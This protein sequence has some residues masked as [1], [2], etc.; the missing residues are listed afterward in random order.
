VTAYKQFS[1]GRGLISSG[2]DSNGREG[3][4]S[5]EV[6][7]ELVEAGRNASEVLELVEEAFNEVSL[8]VD[9]RID[10][11]LNPPV[12]LGWDVSPDAVDLGQID[13]SP[14][15]ITTI[16]DQV[17]GLGE[18]CDQTDR[19]LFIGGLAWCQR[20]ADGQAITID[21]SIDLST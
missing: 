3:D 10:G 7:G 11:S 2:P 16:G 4:G 8:P 9:F 13:K 21:D 14:S 6:A 1:L 5:E 17:A 15:V 20:Q 18:A 19:G 12:A